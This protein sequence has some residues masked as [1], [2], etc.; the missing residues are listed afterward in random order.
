MATLNEVRL[1]GRLGNDPRI[2]EK[3]EDGKN[4]A[5]FNLATNEDYTDSDGNR[6]ERTEWHK[7]IAFG[8]HAKNCG[9]YLQKGSEVYIA[10]RLATR[11][12]P[13]DGQT[14]Y[15]TEIQVKNIQFLSKRN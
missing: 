6:K 5:S 14:H 15:I 4:L 12:Y 13:K 1:I 7:I 11:T 9:K 2:Q 3:E 10:G 8:T